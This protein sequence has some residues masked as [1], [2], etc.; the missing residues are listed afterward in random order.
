MEPVG[1]SASTSAQRPQA[2][3]GSNVE[4]ATRGHTGVTL[5]LNGAVWQAPTPGDRDLI[6]AH[7]L[8]RRQVINTFLHGSRSEGEAETGPALRS[9]LVGVAIAVGIALVIV[10]V[11]LVDATRHHQRQAQA[12]PTTS[13]SVS[14]LPRS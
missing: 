1:A 11:A 12:A 8:R 4:L 9:V 6:E 7:A 14:G 5:C 13:A 3:I 2:V 10:I